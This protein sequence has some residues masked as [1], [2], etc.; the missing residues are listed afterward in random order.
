ME[1][2]LRATEMPELTSLRLGYGGPPKQSR[3][4]IFQSAIVV[5]SVAAVTALAAQDQQPRSRP[6]WPCVGK[7]DPSYFTVA[8]GS[9]GQV[10]LFDPSEVG[11]S[12]VVMIAAMK[13]EETVFRA[14]GT[15]AEGVHEFSI[16]VDSTIESAMFSVSLQCL[17]VV[18]IVRPSGDELRAN[19]PGVEYHQFQAG[20]V[21]TLAKPTP[22]GWTVRVAGKGMFFLVLQAK[23]DL[24]LDRVSFV[25]PGGR[26]GHEGLFPIKG[27]PKRGV[28]Q[29]LEVELSGV[30]QGPR[31]RF[32]S[33]AAETIQDLTLEP[34]GGAGEDR[35]FLGEVTPRARQFR[36]AVSGVDARGF[37]FQR[38]HAPLFTAEAR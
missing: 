8:E 1:Y 7:P 18:E 24:S 11:D 37:A 34:Q 29:Q 3:M 14:A 28:A 6:G 17:Q 36:L 23:T 2:G 13:H 19:D 22:G 5:I 4:R 21:V 35:S 9:G 26:P 38:V 31:F 30:V 32:I 16:P 20:R 33:S 12:S 25:E 27:S 15:L 10:F